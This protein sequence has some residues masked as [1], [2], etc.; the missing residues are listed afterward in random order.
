MTTS[1]TWLRSAIYL[2][3]I[4][5]LSLDS[6]SGLSQDKNADQPYHDL[7]HF[8]RVFG[9]E[10]YYR[11]YLPKGYDQTQSRYPVIYF[12]HGWGGRH[13]KD[14][15]A[16]LE[17]EMIKDLVDKYN[18]ILVMWDGNIEEIEPR[19]YNIGNHE[20]VKYKIQ[21]KDY[22]RELITH[23]DSTCRTLNDRTHRGII[24]FSMGGIMSYYLAGKYPDKVCAAVYMTGSPE[25]F[26]G[27]PENHTL[28][29]VR[30][31]FKNLEG[32]KIRMHNSTHDELVYLNEE[33]DKGA[34]W[35]GGLYYDYWQF[36]G[37]HMV[38]LPGETQT[39][40]RAMKFVVDAFHDPLPQPDRWWHYDLYPGF[41]VWGYH[42]NSNK[43]EPGFVYLKNVSK[44]G[45]G[46]HSRKWLPDGPPI[47]NLKTDVVTG[48][49]Y[50]SATNY[51]VVS[52]SIADKKISETSL[53]SDKDGKIKISSTGDQEFGI[54]QQ[55]ATP[56]L[57]VTEYGL[58]NN[59][60]FLRVGKEN[61]LTV[62][63]FNRG[64]RVDDSKTAELEL[65]TRDSAVS[66]RNK[67][68]TVKLSSGKRLAASSSF[69]ININKQPP[70][71]G[72][73]AWVKFYL[74]M[75]LGNQKYLDEFVVPVFFDV[76]ALDTIRADD[77]VII[78]DKTFGN[79]NAD[80]KV[81]AGESIM[82]YSG[83]HRLRLYT[84]DPYVETQNEKLIDEVLPAKWPDGFTLSS[85]IKISDQCP[86]GR[87]IE[88]LASY[89]TKGYMPIERNLHWG[90]VFVTVGN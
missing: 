37:G 39:F 24:G 65:T 4:L 76:P 58:E 82:L 68:G 9:R 5:L 50:K 74:K 77:G 86:K 41:D 26:I 18:V 20:D 27:Y 10:K 70:A 8:S 62:T 11:L 64:G 25:F 49:M 7:T 80:G 63:L 85:V 87:V 40:E 73:P 19:P 75:K 46:I 13:F 53:L 79:G 33:V 51:N 56:D 89:E 61:K 15:N 42:V 30:Y 67:V 72:E 84:D 47:A 14:D 2:G 43:N 57:I 90:K 31:A 88:L 54:Y 38:D 83:K 45:F 59:L 81:S 3:L 21:M 29:P 16:K 78:R 1:D 60:R 17:Y 55:G 35:E 66:I 34:R 32:V 23:V 6:F 71:H 12:F 52:Y 48:S 44:N 36:H 28:Y 22:F 69:E